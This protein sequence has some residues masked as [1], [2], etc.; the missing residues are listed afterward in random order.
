MDNLF[1]MFSK[2]AWAFLSPSNLLILLL[3]LGVF[4]LAINRITTAKKLLI[5]TALFFF[6][7]MI[8][9]ISDYLIEPLEN[10]FHKPATLPDNIDGI[11]VLGGGED[12]KRSDSWQVAEL[13]QGADRFIAA[14]ELS[15]LYPEAPIFFS[16]GSSSIR[17]K[18]TQ[19]VS[20]LAPKIFQQMGVDL[21]R[22]RFDEKA[23]NT[24][25]NFKYLKPML[26]KE[27]GNYLLITSAFHMPRSVGI[28]RKQQ[29][30]V[31]P[32][33]VDYR[34][35]SADNRYFDI[36]FYDRLKA[37]EPAWKE[38]IGLTAYYFTDKTSS[39]FPK[40]LAHDLTLDIHPH[41]REQFREFARE[42]AERAGKP[43]S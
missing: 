33:P 5:P 32:Y 3:T 24:Y 25:E 23:R 22:I 42:E 40:P 41:N 12:L 28:A 30:P 17:D 6:S 13:G 21:K 34:S 39:W 9:P 8:Y 18:K 43:L 36:D 11:I 10:R 1:F 4:F 26:P 2:I 27:N 38:W 35:N 20:R 37:L 29:I 16:G 7:L 14:S 19:T 31:I 15:I